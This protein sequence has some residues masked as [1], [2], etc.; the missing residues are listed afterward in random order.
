MA[1][2]GFLLG[3]RGEADSFFIE[4]LSK[5]LGVGRDRERC[6]LLDFR[7]MFLKVETGP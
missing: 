4:R 5:S 1:A 6:G 3:R 7:G 2:I